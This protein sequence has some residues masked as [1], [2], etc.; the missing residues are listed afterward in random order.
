MDKPLGTNYRCQY[1]RSIGRGEIKREVALSYQI[2]S[3]PYEGL[4]WLYNALR[5]L[6]AHGKGDFFERRGWLGMRDDF[7]QAV[8]TI[9]L[10]G[11]CSMAFLTEDGQVQLTI[12]EVP[13]LAIAADD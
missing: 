3:S 4:R 13:L 7:R 8:R 1:I 10:G 2:V 5:S 12:S 6:P 9:Q 11:E